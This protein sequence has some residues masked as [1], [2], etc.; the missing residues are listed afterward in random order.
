MTITKKTSIQKKKMY[1]KPVFIL[2][3]LVSHYV[4]AQEIE[5]LNNK[6]F[7][8]SISKPKSWVIWDNPNITTSLQKF[9]FTEEE[10]REILKNHNGSILIFS[11]AKEKRGTVG[12]SIIPI[13]QIYAR[14]N[15]AK[16]FEVFEKTMTNSI[17]SIKQYFQEFEYLEQ[18]KAIEVSGMK[19]WTVYNKTK[20]IQNGREII[21]KSRV[22]AVPKGNYF[23]QI[24]FTDGFEK[25]DCQNLY[26]EIIK[27]I[28]IIN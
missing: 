12:A 18:P 5:T 16:S 27:S 11:Y 28:K 24:S 6:E 13:V 7:G 25:N 19:A 1:T 10:R 23:L 15:G 26:S 4:N 9:D 22:I 21:S 20:L 2:L 3:I 17:E 8:I 14:S